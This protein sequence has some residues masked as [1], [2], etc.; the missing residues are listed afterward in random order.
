MR[1]YIT[2]EGGVAT[3]EGYASKLIG[4]EEITVVIIEKDT[5]GIDEREALP[6]TAQEISDILG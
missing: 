1:V 2:V 5:G 3:V 4:A 6:L